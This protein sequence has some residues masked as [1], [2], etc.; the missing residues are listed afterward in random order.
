MAR[1]V[2]TAKA[3]KM[4]Y[5]LAVDAFVEGITPEILPAELFDI[6]E[7]DAQTIRQKRYSDKIRLDRA[8]RRVA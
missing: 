7:A 5:E 3:G 1:V 4:I 8:K 6:S 2:S